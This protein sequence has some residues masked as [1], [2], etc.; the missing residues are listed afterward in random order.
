MSRRSILSIIPLLQI[1]EQY[2][3]DIDQF[4]NNFGLTRELLI[5]ATTLSSDK[6]IAIVSDLITQ[7]DQP[8]LGLKL[9]SLVN[10]TSYGLYALLLMT[11]P[12]YWLAAKSAIEFQ[13]LSL[14]Y[15]KLSLHSEPSYIELRMSS[16]NYPEPVKHFIADRDLMGTYMFFSQLL[17]NIKEVNI[18]IGVCR[19]A[20]KGEQL[21]L[22]KRAFRHSITFAQEFTWI[23]L[24]KT[25]VEQPQPY[26][27]E[28]IHEY[29][30]AQAQKAV[31][32]YF[33]DETDQLAPIVNLINSYTHNFPTAE[34]VASLLNMSDRSLRRTL[35]TNGISF[36]ELVSQAKL[37]RAKE[38][39][40]ST[41]LSVGEIAEQLGYKE[42]ASFVRAFKLWTNQTPARFRKSLEQTD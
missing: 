38:L 34:Q 24:P 13:S 41:K 17:E 11:A 27:D 42:S 30:R 18:S 22:Y 14:L 5:G 23:R 3:I 32:Q 25:L 29:Y 15:S 28:L 31:L 8:L 16:T 40:L 6:E 39:L 35:Q 37:K 4:L 2:E 12:N 1:L 36:R 33:S 10:F 19:P 21:N 9:G 26:G 20:P 7:I